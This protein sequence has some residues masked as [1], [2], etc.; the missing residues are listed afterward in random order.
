MNSLPSKK[1][2][3]CGSKRSEEGAGRPGRSWKVA[4]PIGARLTK[5]QAVPVTLPFCCANPVTWDEVGRPAASVRV[6]DSGTP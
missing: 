5:V 4:C 2:C 6:S 1:Y 3:P